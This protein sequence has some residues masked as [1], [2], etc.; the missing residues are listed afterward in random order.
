[1]KLRSREVVVGLESLPR[2]ALLRADGL[3]DA[4]IERPFVAIANSY[5][6]IVPGHLHLRQ[7]GEAVAAGVRE[8]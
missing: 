5:N 8:S 4:D 3:T 2:R 7:L 1:M 6:N